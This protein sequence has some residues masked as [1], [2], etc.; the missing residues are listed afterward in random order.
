MSYRMSHTWINWLYTKLDFHFLSKKEFEDLNGLGMS[1][2]ET[3][4]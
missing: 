4:F 3:K 1:K 2:S